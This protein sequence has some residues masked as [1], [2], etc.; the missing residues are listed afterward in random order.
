MKLILIRHGETKANN[1][2][3]VQGQRD[4]KNTYLSR[5]GIKQI[6]LTA[7]EIN[8]LNLK[9]DIIYSSSLIR[10]I[11]S[12]KIIKKIT[13]YDG[14]IVCLDGLMERNF[15]P[16]E[17]KHYTK[18]YPIINPPKSYESNEEIINRVYNT[19]KYIYSKEKDKTVLI[20][21]HSHTIKSLFIDK[22][23][24][25]HD[26]PIEN[27]CIITCEFDGNKIKNKKVLYNKK[28]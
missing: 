18:V 6:K 14:E 22:N 21:A 11:E 4:C 26:F 19:I 24:D 25:F 9:Y 16:Y 27:G 3:L 2:G 5:K 10:A 7:E 13:N 23:Y 17:N 28:I 12:A 1:L 20:T 8:N 15:G